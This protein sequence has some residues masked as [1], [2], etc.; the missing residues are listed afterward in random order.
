[1]PFPPPAQHHFI[2]SREGSRADCPSRESNLQLCPDTQWFSYPPCSLL[3]ELK[4]KK[5][6][7]THIQKEKKKCQKLEG[8]FPNS[9]LAQCQ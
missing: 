4:K 7:H 2:Y 8:P 1:M 6:L 3:K 9:T 5:K